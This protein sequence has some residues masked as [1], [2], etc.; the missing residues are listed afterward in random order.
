MKKIFLTILLLIFSSNA[1]ATYASK[2]VVTGG[3]AGNTLTNS[4][5]EF[6]GV[7]V[8]IDDNTVL[9]FDRIGSDSDTDPRGIITRIACTLNAAKTT[10]TWGS[11]TN[12]FDPG[13]D[14][15]VANFFVRNKG[16]S[17]WMY[18]IKYPVSDLTHS[19]ITLIK[20]TDIQGTSWGA[21]TTIR[22]DQVG[23]PNF[24]GWLTTASASINYLVLI[25]DSSICRIC[26][27]QNS[28]ADATDTFTAGPTFLTGGTTDWGEGTCVNISGGRIICVLR[29][30]SSSPGHYLTQVNCTS[31]GQSCTAPTSTGLGTAGGIKVTPKLIQA[32]GHSDRLVT[33]FYDRGDARAKISGP[34]LEDSAFNG[35]W[36]PIYLIGTNSQGNGNIT[37][38]D[39]TNFKYLIYTAKQVGTP[40]AGGTTNTLWWILKD[41]YMNIRLGGATIST[42]N[43]NENSDGEE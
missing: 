28:D 24:G 43:T 11:E 13:T 3:S 37:V 26:A 41:I 10:C 1:W 12:I 9:K 42:L 23:R 33:Y 34:T 6:N 30:N 19:V 8:Q 21:E 18:I 20:S 25:G 38:I 2:N 7:L 16:D 4:V 15:S 29:D 27:L 40:G 5:Y 32:A 22:A 31:Y 35:N 17:L 36:I 14:Y 39:S